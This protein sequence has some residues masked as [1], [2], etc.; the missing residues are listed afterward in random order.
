MGLADDIGQFIEDYFE[1]DGY[2]YDL[3]KSFGVSNLWLLPH[4]FSG[5]QKL[6]EEIDISM[7]NYSENKKNHPKLVLFDDPN[8]IE[9]HR[10]EYSDLERTIK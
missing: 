10:E 9:K 3:K 4:D 5:S 6:Y 2:F 1:Y 7:A 8:E